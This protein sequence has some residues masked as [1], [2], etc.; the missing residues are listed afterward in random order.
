MRRFITGVLAA[1]LFV[2]ARPARADW[3]VEPAKVDTTVKRDKS[4]VPKAAAQPTQS[5]GGFKEVGLRVVYDKSKVP[6]HEKFRDF[7]EKNG[8]YEQMSVALNRVFRF[9]QLVTIHWVDCGMVNAFW[10]GNDRIVMCYELVDQ[11]AELF[12]PKLKDKQQLKA[13]VMSALMF[14]FFHELGHGAIAMFKLP[15]VGR[16]EDAVDQLAALVLLKAGKDG[17]AMALLGAEFFHLWAQTGKKTPYFD[18]H[19]LDDQRFYNVLCLI[20]G[21]D[22]TKF[23]KMVGDQALPESRAK[24]CTTEYTK[25]SAAWDTLLK[26]HTRAWNSEEAVA[27]AAT[28][29]T[30]EGAAIHVYALLADRVKIEIAKLPADKRKSAAEE[31]ISRLG[32]LGEQVRDACKKKAWPKDGISCVEQSVSLT[33]LDK[34]KLPQ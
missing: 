3:D 22:T 33:A 27:S 34:C 8:M 32:Q 18:E 5:A 6:Q 31:A 23:A 25:I 21:S 11:L 24:R 29:G 14:T 26:D 4:S 9:P 30:C 2:I 10:D 7:I 28:S 1:G 20:Y 16:E 19:A 17:P 13:A 15:A 12:A